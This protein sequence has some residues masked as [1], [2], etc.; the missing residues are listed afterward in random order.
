MDAQNLANAQQPGQPNPENI[1]N[2]V[3]IQ[4]A[5]ANY[6]QVPTDVQMQTAMSND[7]ALGLPPWYANMRWKEFYTNPEALRQMSSRWICRLPAFKPIPYSQAQHVK[8][9]DIIKGTIPPPQQQPVEN[10]P[11]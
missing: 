9:N 8:L 6:G 7:A 5:M 10:K 1:P 3:R 4:A 2:E 11:N